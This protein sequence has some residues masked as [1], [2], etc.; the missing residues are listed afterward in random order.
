MLRLTSP[1]QHRSH[2]SQYTAHARSGRAAR[3][4]RHAVTGRIGGP[5]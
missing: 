2:V 1:L 3:R 5:R 4:M